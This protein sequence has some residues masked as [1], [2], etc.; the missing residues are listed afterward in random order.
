MPTTDA[1]RLGK[2]KVMKG[3]ERLLAFEQGGLI[4]NNAFVADF[5]YSALAYDEVNSEEEA[6][7]PSINDFDKARKGIEAGE[8]TYLP[9]ELNS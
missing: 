7:T 1:E 3:C 8:E 4:D 9:N 2:L 6:F 5:Q